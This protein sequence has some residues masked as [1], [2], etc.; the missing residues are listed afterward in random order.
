[1][2]N[3]DF[4]TAYKGNITQQFTRTSWEVMGTDKYGWVLVPEVPKEVANIPAPLIVSAENVDN[5]TEAAE[6]LPAIQPA[7]TRKSKKR[8]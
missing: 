2:K 1:M 6:T 4:V 5:V 7:K 3:R 8:K